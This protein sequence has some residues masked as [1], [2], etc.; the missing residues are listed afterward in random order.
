MNR[1][2]SLDIVEGKLRTLNASVKRAGHLN[3]LIEPSFFMY[4]RYDKGGYR[5]YLHQAMIIILP[6]LLPLV[7]L[8]LFNRVATRFSVAYN[9]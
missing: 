6:S 7:T 8:P 9:L 1:R 4:Y 2:W 5:T 3:Y